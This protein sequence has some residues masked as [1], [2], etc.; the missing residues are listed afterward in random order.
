M[1]QSEQERTGIVRGWLTQGSTELSPH[2]LDAV[3][4]EF[5]TTRQDR[6]FRWPWSPRMSGFAKLVVA[7]A[8]VVV[9]FI[10]GTRFA[11]DGGPAGPG[12]LASD[13]PSPIPSPTYARIDPSYRE[14][15]FI[16]LPPPGARP[17]SLPATELVAS[18]A[19]PP[20]GG[21]GYIGGG[22]LY[23]DGR[24][25]WNE[26]YADVSRSTGFLEQRLSPEGVELVRV[27]IS[28]AAADSIPR[29]DPR[30]L[31]NQLPAT[32]WEDVTV[33]AYV[34][35]GFAACVFAESQ[36]NPADDL[37]TTLPDRLAMLPAAAAD[38]LRDRE[39]VLSDAYDETDDCLGLSTAEART[40]VG[41]LRDGGLEQDGGR[42]KWLLE[43]H[44]AY[45][46]AGPNPWRGSIWFEPILPD[47][48]FTCTACG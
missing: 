17:S 41:Y 48:T 21:F 25:V 10:A 24:L 39:T 4:L 16:G 1:T 35:S 32:A 46:E 47:G 23:I 37:N 13:A 34:P 15:G 36:A 18:F 26:Y 20:S 11:P 33:R 3:L 19:L 6:P 22:R 31:P 43:Y 38:L 9:A 14:V 28:E 12:S 2:V 30:T 40:L 45:D 44:T 8:A 5:P 29:L 42:N 7:T 27:L